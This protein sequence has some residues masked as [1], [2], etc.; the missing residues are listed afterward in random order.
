MKAISLWQPHA[1]LI[2]LGLKGYETRSWGTSYQGPLVICSAKR[3]QKNQHLCWLAILEILESLGVETSNLPCW[4]ELPFGCAIAIVDLTN[5]IKM[6]QG[7]IAEQTESERLVG[8]WQVNR[9]AWKLE[10]IRKI[11]PFPIR[12]KQ[13]LFE[14]DVDL[15][16]ELEAVNV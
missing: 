1:S 3:S 12:G 11:N 9:F 8:D 6:T 14:V 16:E 5:C 10:N 15:K 13:G 2:P 4:D 7:F